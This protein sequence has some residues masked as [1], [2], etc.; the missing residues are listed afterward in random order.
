MSSIEERRETIL[1]IIVG[2]YISRAA[3]VASRTIAEDYALQVSPATIRNDVA[4]LESEG[5]ITHPHHS[6][7]SVPT[8]KAYRCYV[9]LLGDA[10]DLPED[11]Q[12]FFYQL[13][14]EARDRIEQQLRLAVFFLARFAHN[15][16]IV[17]S[18]RAPE[19][20]FKHLD[21]VS[22]QDFVAL[23]ILVLYG[24]GIR[25]RI[26]SFDE[27]VSQDELTALS[28]KFNA[29]YGGMTGNGILASEPK[30]PREGRIV[31]QAVVDIMET[32]NRLEYGKPCIEGLCLL[33]N[34]PEFYQ[35]PRIITILELLEKESWLANVLGQRAC[36]GKAEVII[37][38]EN[39]EE[40]L[41][42]FSLVVSQY[43][44][45]GKAS[46]VVGV[47]G[48]KRMDYSRVISSVNSVSTLLS[49][50]VAEYI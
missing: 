4:Y 27:A 3:P 15:L 11:E 7:G 45:S 50:S 36:M 43:G 1:K 6:A 37:G 33:L 28:N 18:P 39:K 46:G 17:T 22:L 13:L 21:L 47:L 48:P 31:T 12:Y 2:E 9:G 10:L 25:Q 41:Q 14:R 40:V 38:E 44:V 24:V 30:L 29:I 32:E 23:L 34:Q 35:S 42:D 19:S 26:L 20:R 16:A 49:E 8:D 5:Y